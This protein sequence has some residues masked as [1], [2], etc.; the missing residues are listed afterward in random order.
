VTEPVSVEVRLSPIPALT[1]DPDVA[2][3]LLEVSREDGDRR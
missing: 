3:E 1:V 2:A